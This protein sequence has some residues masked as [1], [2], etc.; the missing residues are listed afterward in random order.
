MFAP[1]QLRWTA[2]GLIPAIV[3]DAKS[4]RV[5]M[6]AYMNRKSLLRTLETGE[7]WFFSRSRDCLWHKGEQSGHVQLVRRIQTDCDQDTLLIQVDQVGAGA[8]HEGFASCFHYAVEGERGA[9][10]GAASEE[11]E[12]QG[13]TFDPEQVYGRRAAVVLDELY[14]VVVDR[15]EHPVEGAYT[16]YLFDK[17]LDKIL[18]KVGE[19]SAEVIIAG[20]D[21]EEGPLVYEVADLLYHLLVLLAEKRIRPEAVWSELASRRG[22]TDRHGIEKPRVE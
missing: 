6:M 14:D 1:D 3:Q 18:K 21:A 20:K 7:T 17:G 8:C 11:A 9:G 10:E 13:R 15:R 19:E 16:S 4:G 5:L 12:P 2:E 22:T